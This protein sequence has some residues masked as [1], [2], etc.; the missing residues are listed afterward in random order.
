M[1]M[2]IKN[3]EFTEV[4]RTEIVAAYNQG[5]VRLCHWDASWTTV[6]D[7]LDE[8]LQVAEVIL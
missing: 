8:C 3:S 1:Y 7:S 5:L 4:P 2:V 6:P